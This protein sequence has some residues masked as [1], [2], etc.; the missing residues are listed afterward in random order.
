MQAEEEGVIER[1]GNDRSGIDNE[2]NILT[3]CMYKIV[4]AEE[5][6]FCRD[7]NAFPVK[8]FGQTEIQ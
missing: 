6:M 4:Q 2:K 5:I 8:V 7:H 1:Y 3:L